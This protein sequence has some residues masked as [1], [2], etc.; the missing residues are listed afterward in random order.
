MQSRYSLL[1]ALEKNNQV[2]AEEV[3]DQETSKRLQFLRK[4]FA[5]DHVQ[6]CTERIASVFLVALRT[7]TIH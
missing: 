6:L 3:Q 2:G 1:R 5:L 4:Y 7:G